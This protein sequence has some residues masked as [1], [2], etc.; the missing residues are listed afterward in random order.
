MATAVSAKPRARHAVPI[1]CAHGWRNPDGRSCIWTPQG[2]VKESIMVVR[3]LAPAM[4]VLIG[5][6][7]LGACATKGFVRDEIAVVSQRI[8]TLEQR[9]TA[10]DTA[11][12]QALAEAQAATGQ[13][14]GNSQRLEQL[15]ARVD[16]IEQRMREAPR[17]RPR[18]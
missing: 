5:S 10:G 2:L 8:D 16:Q 6:L 11:S 13:I 1:M 7:G 12:R 3:R 4:V 18:N 17:R 15:N 9:V 14:Q